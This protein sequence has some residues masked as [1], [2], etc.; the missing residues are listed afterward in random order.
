MT[1]T[2]DGDQA[3]SIILEI[4]RSRVVDAICVDSV[5]GLVPPGEAEGDFSDITVQPQLNP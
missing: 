5:A 3:F 4:M 2:G 1:Q